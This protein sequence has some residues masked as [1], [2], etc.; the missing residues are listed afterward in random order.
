MRSQPR[1]GA[2]PGQR[3]ADHPRKC[4]EDGGWKPG[5]TEWEPAQNQTKPSPDWD[6]PRH[7]KMAPGSVPGPGLDTKPKKGKK[8]SPQPQQIGGIIMSGSVLVSHT[9]PHAV[10]SALRGLTSGFGMG[11]GVSLS[12]WPPKQ[13]SGTNNICTCQPQPTHTHGAAQENLT[14]DA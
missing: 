11:P 9:L 7:P 10:P 6:S 13:L 8:I 4:L 3:R 5:H 14:V 12:P 2:A 1:V